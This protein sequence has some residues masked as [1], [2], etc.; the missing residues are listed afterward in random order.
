ME[1]DQNE[2]ILKRNDNMDW[3]HWTPYDLS[4][5]FIHISFIPIIFFPSQQI[6]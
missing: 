3:T 2:M 6:W 1:Y 4:F 5:K